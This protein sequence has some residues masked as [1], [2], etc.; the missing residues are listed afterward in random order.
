MPLRRLQ[1]AVCFVERWHIDAV[2]RRY[3]HVHMVV[4]PA[5]MPPPQT[6]YACY[7]ATR[8]RAVQ[9]TE[10]CC[11]ERCRSPDGFVFRAVTLMAR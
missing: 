9:G 3:C 6:H 7:F 4:N 1:R 8:Q 10:G 2:E 5:R 11:F